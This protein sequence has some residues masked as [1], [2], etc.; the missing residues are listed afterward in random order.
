MELFRLISLK[1]PLQDSLEPFLESYRI[2]FQTG[3]VDSALTAAYVFSVGCLIA[4][5][6][7][8]FFA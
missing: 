7:V 3:D 4:C 2:G 6:L 8:S 1:K 5:F